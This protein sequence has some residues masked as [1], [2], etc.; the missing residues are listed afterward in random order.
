[1]FAEEK[2]A[3]VNAFGPANHLVE[4][5]TRVWKEHGGHDLAKGYMVSARQPRNIW[6]TALAVAGLVIACSGLAAAQ[7]TSPKSPAHLTVTIDSRQMAEP[8]S[9]YEFGMFIE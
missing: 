1:M 2:I 5:A 7:Q 3:L 9:K 6:R 4:V 8:T